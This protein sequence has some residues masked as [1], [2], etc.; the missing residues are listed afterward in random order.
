MRSVDSIAED[1]VE[2]AAA[3]DPS[4]GSPD[5]TVSCRI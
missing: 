4:P 5:T 3:L 2:R 1:Y